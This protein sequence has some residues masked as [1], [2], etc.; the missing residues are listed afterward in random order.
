MEDKYKE[1]ISHAFLDCVKRTADRVGGEDLTNRPFHKALLSKEAL[2]WSRFERSF[3]TSLGQGVMEKV[4]L[5]AA[6]SNGASELGYQTQTIVDLSES[7]ISA[8]NNH[9]SD[10]RGNRARGDWE[11]DVEIIM[12]QPN[13]GAIISERVISDICWVKDG[14]RNYMSIKTVKPNIDQT[15]EAKRDML[16]LKVYDP[17]C[18]VYFGMYYNPY[19]DLPESYKWSPPLKVFNF[20]NDPCVLIGKKYWDTLGGDGFYEELIAIVESVGE[21]ARSMIEF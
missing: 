1:R 2:F 10:L 8:I 7:K 14:V 15:A 17:S 12:S 13:A 6:Q 20:I 11:R 5:I 18:N 9:I 21:Q 19:G 16:K 3:S 4:S